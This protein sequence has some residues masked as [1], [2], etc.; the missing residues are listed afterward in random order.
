[1]EVVLSHYLLSGGTLS[2]YMLLVLLTLIICLLW[3]LA[4]YK[5]YFFP[6]GLI[7]CVGEIFRH[8][9]NTL[10]L[11][12]Y[13]PSK[14]VIHHCVWQVFPDYSTGGVSIFF[15]IYEPKFFCKKRAVNSLCIYLFGY[16][17]LQL[18]IH[19]FSSFRLKHDIFII[20]LTFPC[21]KYNMFIK[22]AL[23][24]DLNINP[25]QFLSF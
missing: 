7:K 11:L 9:V 4:R 19:I 13:S 10:F 21:M 16:L 17:F 22:F 14:F 6:L 23:S 8:Y 18:W 20:C 3:H 24:L 12:K 1:M 15:Y 25:S 5:Q 2:L